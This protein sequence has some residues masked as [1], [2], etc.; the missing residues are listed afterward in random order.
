MTTIIINLEDSRKIQKD[1]LKDITMVYL[2]CDNSIVDSL[3]IHV[4]QN[5]VIY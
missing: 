3:I 1:K 5:R 4:L 2:P